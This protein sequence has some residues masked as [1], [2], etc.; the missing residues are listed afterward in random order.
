MYEFELTSINNSHQLIIQFAQTHVNSIR[1]GLGLFSQ[2]PTQPTSFWRVVLATS[3]SI[4]L[5]LSFYMSKSWHYSL[6]LRC[7]LRAHYYFDLIKDFESTLNESEFSNCM[8]SYFRPL[9][10]I[11]SMSI[12]KQSSSRKNLY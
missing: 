1:G 9:V 8:R 11:E 10:S 4:R 7:D 5:D 6:S 2:N 3:F 12:S